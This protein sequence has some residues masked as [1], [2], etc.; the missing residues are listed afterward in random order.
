MK[1]ALAGLTVR[2]RCFLAAGVTVAVIAVLFGQDML[3]PVAVLLLLLPILSLVAVRRTR[4]RLAGERVV[5]PD[6]VPTGTTVRVRLGVRNTSRLP[7]GVLMLADHVPYALGSRP[8]FVLNRLWPQQV[9][10]VQYTVRPDVRGR[11]RLGPIE[12]T[13]TD[14][15]GLYAAQR[16][17]EDVTVLSVVPAAR[18]LP[19]VK[20]ESRRRGTGDNRSRSV[21]VH[22]DDDAAT[23]EYRRG[24]DLRKVHWPSTARIGELMVRLEEQPWQ[25]KAGLLLDTRLFGHRGDGPGSSLEWGVSAAASIGVHLVRG[26]YDLR[27][28]TD[29]GAEVSSGQTAGMSVGPGAN[30]G[31]AGGLLDLLADLRPSH[32]RHLTEAVR[33]LRHIG[34]DGVL[35]AILGLQT[36]ETLAELVPLRSGGRTCV[37]VLIDATSWVRTPAGEPDPLADAHS[38]A[39]RVLAAAGWRVL[40]ARHGVRLPELWRQSASKGG[41]SVNTRLSHAA[42]GPNG[43]AGPHAGASRFGDADFGAPNVDPYGANGPGANGSGVNGHNG[44]AR[45]TYRVEPER[46]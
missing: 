1:R 12:A 13:I 45:G 20:L 10:T 38:T 5:S 46:W 43:A 36:P 3:L 9:A 44:R 22:G 17:I 7:T 32:G 33:R 15:F 31:E 27:T 28:V 35:I 34:G 14:P 26:G 40:P 18:K 30:R 41:I 24:D 19:T 16:S 11:Y 25:S 37:A 8:R 39:A 2:G 29:A 6:R 21:A 23:R 42:G 4:Y